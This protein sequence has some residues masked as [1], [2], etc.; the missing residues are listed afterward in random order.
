MIDS[1]FAW[2]HKPASASANENTAIPPARADFAATELVLIDPTDN[3]TIS[4]YFLSGGRDHYA[5][6]Y[7]ATPLSDTWVY[8]MTHFMWVQAQ[9]V[10]VPRPRMAQSC[11]SASI[12][13]NSVNDAD[14]VTA[15]IL[16]FGGVEGND[17]DYEAD[18]S[19]DLWQCNVVV[20]DEP[21]EEGLSVTAT[22][23][24][25]DSTEGC[26]T[27]R[28]WHTAVM[29]G[30]VMVIFGGRLSLDKELNASNEV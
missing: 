7:D 3:S 16:V 24:Q 14:A 9:Q 23:K 28:A 2:R 22:W 21:G 20:D 4:T 29:L 6:A 1:L 5:I 8:S 25:L 11:V 30:E 12:T 17:G 26:P 19:G 13:T 15:S 27:P 10:N 18:L